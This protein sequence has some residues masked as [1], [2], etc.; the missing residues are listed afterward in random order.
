MH[1]IKGSSAMMSL[2]S[3][4]TIAHVL[5]DLFSYIREEKPV[6]NVSDICD[7]VFKVLD[8]I[9]FEIEHLESDD[10]RNPD[11][12]LAETLKAYLKEIKGAN[13]EAKQ[14]SEASVQLC[15]SKKHSSLRKVTVFFDDF[16]NMINVRAFM[17]VNKLKELGEIVSYY[18]DTL[19]SSESCIRALI[20]NGLEVVFSCDLPSDKLR[21]LIEGITD[22]KTAVVQSE[23]TSE[24]ISCAKK[25]E[26]EQSEEKAP[27]DIKQAENQ[28]VSVE[29][30][31][32]NVKQ[33]II[34]VNISKLDKLIN[35]V[36]EIV[37]SESMVTNSPDQDG[38]PLENFTKSSMQLRKLTEELQDLVLSVRMI[39]IELIF[40][41]MHRI[42]R[43][44]SKKLDK[45]VTLEVIGEDTEVDK[46]VLDNLSDPLMHLIRNSMDHGIETKEERVKTGKNLVSK[47][48]LEAKNTG[49]EVII[50]VS[51]DGR[52]LDREKILKK[53]IENG[54]ITKTESLTDQEIYNIIL[55]PGFSTNEKVTEY[56]GRGV[57]MDV[58]K[59]NVE[60]IGGSILVSS[61]AGKGF[62][63]SRS[64]IG[65][66]GCRNSALCRNNSR[67]EARSADSTAGYSG[68]G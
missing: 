21:D 16:C 58:V 2:N 12:E 67:S 46:N 6:L 34:S 18:P 17:V 49:G 66:N 36:G 48:T 26:P 13:A 19:D 25:A 44:M 64:N 9:K 41:K 10:I 14:V 8:Y 22:I 43:D 3:I 59:Q 20:E 1:T 53:A 55:L 45:E 31:K 42:V 51:D 28:N 52:G 39:P 33:N 40:S 37:I 56:S 23:N 63:E 7:K 32:H 35:I 27:A 5:E 50:T 62:C 57:G 29:E 11:Y 24:N 4:S 47:I 15:T 65:D 30:S 61:E 38:L 68:L 60:K 54:I